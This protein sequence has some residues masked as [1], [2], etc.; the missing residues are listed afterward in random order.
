MMDLEGGW[1]WRKLLIS[2]YDHISAFFHCISL[3]FLHAP[4]FSQNVNTLFYFF[5][6][7]NDSIIRFL[8]VE[9]RVVDVEGWWM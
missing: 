5:C 7:K 6:L 8:D 9:G 3:D 2:Q 1:M 4:I